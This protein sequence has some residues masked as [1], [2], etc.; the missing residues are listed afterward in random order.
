MSRLN[1]LIARLCPN[2]VPYKALAEIAAKVSNVRW[3]DNGGEAFQYIDLSSVDRV[4]RKIG[5]TAT[6]TAGAAPS[7]AQ[8][9]VRAGD[10]I[11]ATTRPTQM[12]W[13]VIP[14]A[15]DGQ[16]ASTGYCVLRPESREVLTDFLAHLLGAEAF[17]KYVEEK[18]V[19]G[20][21]P[22]IPD[23]VVRAFRIPVPP[24]VIQ[25]EIARVLGKMEMLRAELEAEL[26]YRS[27]QYAHYRDALL[28]ASGGVKQVVFG[29]VA[30]ILRGASPRPIQAFL[31][32]AS[33][34]VNWIKIGDVPAG[35]KY[36]VRTAEKIRPEGVGKSRMVHRGDFVLS[37]SM[38]FGR[39]YIVQMDGCIHDGWLA[40][41]DFESTF[42]PDFLYHILR[43]SPLR[44]QMEQKASNGTVQ[45]LNI[46]LVK[47]LVLSAPP[48]VEQQRIAGLLDRFE[49][50][51]NDVSV[52]LPAELV[53]RR[54][55]Y[56]HYRD[57]LLTFEEAPS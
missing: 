47:S 1:D 26:E 38:S 30:T 28:S 17:R 39:P 23:K 16:I 32:D 36:I 27:L 8:Q 22:S 45:N 57:R 25:L 44:R 37:N 34:G 4:A 54:K 52:G 13:A 24:M 6:I 48:I 42:V 35:G 11:F 31:T 10:V 14:E 9:I 20:N 18:Q 53:A 33:D 55:Q 40:I 5:E 29:E 7:R 21:Y 43:S 41:K 51:T 56:E 2:G 19:P 50:L 12:R 49:A 15:H 46:E 3:Q